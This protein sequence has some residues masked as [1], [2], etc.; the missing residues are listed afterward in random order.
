MALPVTAVVMPADLI[1]ASNGNLATPPL[2]A[3]DFPG[4][5]QGRLHV[6]AWRAFRAMANACLV[7][8]GMVL[9]VTSVADAYRSYKNQLTAFLARYE[10]VSATTYYLTSKS[11][12]KHWPNAKNLGYSS[13]YW[14]LKPGYAMVAVP[15]TSNHGWGL[16]LDIAIVLNGGVAGVYNSAC[17]QWLLANAAK[18]GFSWEAQSEP[19]HVR[20][21]AGDNIPQ[22]ILDFETPP[23]QWPTFAPEWGLWGLYPL[24][25]SK[26]QISVGSKGDIVKYAQ[27]VMRLKAD[28]MKC[29]IDG[30]FGPVTAEGVRNVQRFFRPAKVDGVIDAETWDAIDFLAGT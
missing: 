27:G 21:T 6:N 30:D 25:K 9:T 14:R 15:G 12:R 26:V 11:K 5:G 16:A 18:Y 28:Q 19:W 13:N 7:A 2:T 10:P 3:V 22:A 23:P 17:W 4:R 24:D 8:T 1:N 20:Y 29:T